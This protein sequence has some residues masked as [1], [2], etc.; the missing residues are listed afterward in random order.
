MNKLNCRGLESSLFCGSSA[1]NNEYFEMF[2]L[3]N[4][5]KHSSQLY[6]QR[7]RLDPKHLLF[8]L[9]ISADHLE[10]LCLFTFQ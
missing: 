3:S 2:L 10:M 4:F 5:F 1:S 9:S 6:S 8:I 7:N